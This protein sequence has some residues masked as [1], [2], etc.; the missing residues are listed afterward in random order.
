MI[1]PALGGVMSPFAPSRILVPVDFSSTSDQA[2]D[3]AA[4]LARTFDAD[5][6]VLHVQ[7]ILEDPHMDDSRQA[8]LDRFMDADAPRHLEAME[9][10]GE[11]PAVRTHTHLVRGISASE[12]IVE[13][14]AHLRTEL[15]VIG[16]HGRRGLRHLLLGSV[17]EQV[18]RTAPVPVLTV[19][20]HL[21]GA[22]TITP[23]RM[24][25]ATDFSPCAR[26]AGTIAA[27]WARRFGA[28][29]HLV[30]VVE[31]VVYP[32]FYAVDAL[33]ESQNSRVRDR[34]EQALVDEAAAVFSGVECTPEVIEGRPGTTLAERAAAAGCDLIVL[35]TR[36]L[37]ALKH[38]LLGSVAGEV[39]RHAEVPVLTVRTSDGVG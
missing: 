36:G 35:G 22:E 1:P 28:S 9:A 26:R 27:D 17:A 11:R 4:R 19:P 30:H 15:V 13:R 25:V 31:P 5:L 2:L 37:S 16:T 39:I 6:D 24:L 38:L 12:T 8:A 14:V 7:V 18:I 32:E 3:V 23:R 21:I 34:A 10:S 20:P 29:C 33:P